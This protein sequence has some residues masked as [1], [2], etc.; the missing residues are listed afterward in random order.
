MY[1]YFVRWVDNDGCKHNGPYFEYLSDAEKF[2]K[3]F[4]ENADVQKVI[5]MEVY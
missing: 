4:Q 2:A 3:T 1:S 5:I